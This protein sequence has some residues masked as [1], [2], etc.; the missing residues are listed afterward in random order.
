[1]NFQQKLM[2]K[3]KNQRITINSIKQENNSQSINHNIQYFACNHYKSLKINKI[4][5][6]LINYFFLQNQF[7]KS[8]SSLS[9]HILGTF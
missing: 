7:Q 4:P 3:L 9:K 8:N 1:M 6:S 5:I 2:T